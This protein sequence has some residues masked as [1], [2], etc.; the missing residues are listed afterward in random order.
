LNKFNI[1][2]IL[3]EIKLQFCMNFPHSFPPFGFPFI[4][5]F[6]LIDNRIKYFY[7]IQLNFFMKFPKKDL[8]LCEWSWAWRDFPMCVWETI[9]EL[10]YFN[11]GPPERSL[12]T[13]IMESFHL[14]LSAPTWWSVTM[15][16]SIPNVFVWNHPRRK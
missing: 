3:T 2:L 16:N 9:N 8:I 7:R 10:K 14:P 11:F 13:Y 5:N 4:C 12:Y 15:H 6:Q 1:V